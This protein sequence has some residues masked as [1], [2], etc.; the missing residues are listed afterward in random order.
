MPPEAAPDGVTV[1]DALR[2]ADRRLVGAA[3]GLSYA[4]A[5]R[6]LQLLDADPVCDHHTALRRLAA[7]LGPERHREADVR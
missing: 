5:E 6:F 2:N 7:E 1:S 3:Y 4:E